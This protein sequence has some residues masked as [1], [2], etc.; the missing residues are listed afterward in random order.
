MTPPPQQ[1][2]NHQQACVQ[3]T[4]SDVIMQGHGINPVEYAWMNWQALPEEPSSSSQ[5]SIKANNIFALLK[6]HQYFS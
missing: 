3:L 1:R 6:W 4:Q 2:P 5:L